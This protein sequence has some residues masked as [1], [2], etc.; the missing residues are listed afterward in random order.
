MSGAS[1]GGACVSGVVASGGVPTGL[2]TAI[3]AEVA[4][5][6][7]NLADAADLHHRVD[8]FFP[9]K[10]CTPAWAPPLQPTPAA[11]QSM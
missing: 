2:V 10:S 4:A 7:P 6:G 11:G 9:K 1:V 8:G 5:L 3:Q